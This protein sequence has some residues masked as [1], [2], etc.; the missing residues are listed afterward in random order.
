MRPPEYDH[1]GTPASLSQEGLE[2]P[3]RLKHRF[4]TCCVTLN[5]IPTLSDPH[6]PF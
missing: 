3:E 6:F 5:K 4:G 1:L 2:E